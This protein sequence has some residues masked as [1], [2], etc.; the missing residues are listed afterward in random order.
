MTI[1]NWAVVFR[2][3]DPGEAAVV[4]AKL[5]DVGI[6]VREREETV[7]KVYGLTVGPLSTIEIMVPSLL[8]LDAWEVIADAN[9]EEAP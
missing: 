6:P 1:E 3:N 8:V 4:K 7:A 2:T 9:Q 5:E